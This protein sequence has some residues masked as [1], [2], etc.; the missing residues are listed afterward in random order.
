[1]TWLAVRNDIHHVTIFGDSARVHKREGRKDAIS[2]IIEN[3]D[4]PIG[5]VPLSKNLCDAIHALNLDADASLPSFHQA[6]S[7]DVEQIGCRAVCLGAEFRGVVF[8]VKLVKSRSAVHWPDWDRLLG[9]RLKCDPEGADLH[10]VCIHGIKEETRDLICF[11]DL[12]RGEANIR[13][14]QCLVCAIEQRAIV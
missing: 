8:R 2:A 14:R 11:F 9:L 1:M 6:Q 7:C 10:Q 4:V 5:H 13:G 12:E 3:R